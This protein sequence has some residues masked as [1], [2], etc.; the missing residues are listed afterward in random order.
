M[1]R[2]AV[3][4]FVAVAACDHSRSSSPTSPG[5]GSTPPP[6]SPVVPP[7]PLASILVASSVVTRS[8]GGNAQSSVYISLPP[9]QAIGIASVVITNRKT[10]TFATA[11][12]V[13]NGFD[14]IP[15]SAVVGDTID[16]FATPSN[17]SL[18]RSWIVAGAGRPFL[19]LRT[20][21]TNA[22]MAIETNA[23]V[24]IVFSEPVDTSGLGSRLQL[25]TG[26]DVVA[27]S[28]SFDADGT[29][30]TL[31]PLAA[32]TPGA[33]YRLDVSAGIAGIS[34]ARLAGATSATFETV[35]LGDAG[36]VARLAGTW[37][38]I[39]WRFTDVDFPNGAIWDDPVVG[40]GPNAY[41]RIHVTITPSQSGPA[42][43]LS[44]S[45]AMSWQLG[46]TNNGAAAIAGVGT[47]GAGWWIGR[48]STSPWLSLTVDCEAGDICPLEDYHDFKRSGDTLTFTRRA[49][50]WYLDGI[51]PQ[52]HAREV[53]TLL[54]SAP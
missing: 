5:T 21:P 39:S 11:T 3:F 2:P 22:A 32:L 13:H 47:V 17:G 49:T 25:R 16:V 33:D 43:S 19:V 12:T 34:G 41:Y 51:N 27:S 35:P 29:R 52:W 36:S 23:S 53:L 15:I 44:W 40:W 45:M 48:T 10:G 8:V 9:G 6:N 50:L 42:G 38:A 7:G 20:D 30:A 4:L 28:F 54:R 14:P 1:K 37:D 46:G 18:T 31:R 26:N 24:S